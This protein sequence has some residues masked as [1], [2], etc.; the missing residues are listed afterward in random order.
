MRLNQWVV[1]TARYDL[2]HGKR[3][4]ISALPSPWTVVVVVD[5]E[6]YLYG[7]SAISAA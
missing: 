6:P 2:N 4:R 7:R 1:I 3:G 5:G